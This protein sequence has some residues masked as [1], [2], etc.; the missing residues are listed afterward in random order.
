MVTTIRS[1]GLRCLIAGMMLSAVAVQ[2]DDTEGVVRITAQKDGVIRVSDQASATEAR[3]QSPEVV[4]TGH[5]HHVV[6]GYPVEGQY[7]PD[8][9]YGADPYCGHSYDIFGNNCVA[10]WL[11]AN[12]FAYR[13]RNQWQSAELRAYVHQDMAEKHAWCRGKFGYFVPTGCCGRG[14]PPVGHY[15]MVYPLDPGYF[16]KRDGAVYAAPGYGGPV[17]VP[18]APVVNHTYNYGW[19]VPSSR[20]TPVLHPVAAA[21]VAITPGPVPEAPVAQ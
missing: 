4:P 19:G 12:A 21:P 18:L 11:R 1:T 17:S 6:E 16:D 8:A 3:G 7:C 9:V 10:D 14:C 5:H 2:A 15:S 13:A 20:L